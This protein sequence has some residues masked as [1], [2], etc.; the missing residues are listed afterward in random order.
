MI[1]TCFLKY[2]RPLRALILGLGMATCTL[3]CDREKARGLPGE[4][5][6]LAKVD[7]QTIT[8][9][10]LDVALDKS[11][12]QFATENVERGARGEVLESLIESKAMAFLADKDLSED[13]RKVLDKQ[14]AS[15]RES[16]LLKHY[17]AKQAPPAPV[18]E[19]DVRKYYSEHPQRFGATTERKYELIFSK[20]AVKG[21]ARV[22]MLQALS[23]LSKAER[24]EESVQAQGP[25]SPLG[26]ATGHESEQA[27]HP[28]LKEV[29]E[30]LVVG[31]ASNIIYVQGRAYVARIVGESK[32]NPKP[33]AEVSDEIRKSLQLVHT[34]DAFRKVGKKATDEVKV[35]RFKPQKSEKGADDAT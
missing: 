28:K 24:W 30:T 33:L 23:S 27:L 5:V 14:V 4:E 10:D 20:Q 29:L 31:R 21:N 26:Y 9:F 6:V 2:R 19:A 15:Y 34:R 12:G 17:L 8:Q 22:D 7:G 3:A 35:E 11:L 32:R 1:A 25:D 13:D 18:T 16:L